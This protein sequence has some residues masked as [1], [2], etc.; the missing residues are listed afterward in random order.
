M[1]RNSSVKETDRVKTFSSLDT[2]LEEMSKITNNLMVAGGGEVFRRVIPLAH[3]I[4][5]STVHSD[6]RGD[7]YFPKI[8]GDFHRVYMQDFTS[9]I[10]YTYEIY[11][12]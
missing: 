9:N 3:W 10:N 11:G 1:T 8:P 4:H 5:L 7:T 6:F 2:A 12:R